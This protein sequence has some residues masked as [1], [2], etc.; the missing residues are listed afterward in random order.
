MPFL[1][2]N[3][4]ITQS[5]QQL[6]VR[7]DRKL[8]GELPLSIEYP[9]FVICL[10]TSK[11]QNAL[12]GQFSNQIISKVVLVIRMLP[13]SFKNSLPQAFCGLHFIVNI[14][15]FSQLTSFLKKGTQIL[16][17]DAWQKIV[18]FQYF[19]NLSSFMAVNVSLYTCVFAMVASL[20]VKCK[21]IFK[22]VKGKI[23]VQQK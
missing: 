14:F 21:N 7:N 20:R 11:I 1:T 12:L 2:T 6:F 18:I 9:P 16:E 5:C 4:S 22:L 3:H 8:S 13:T 15:I 19:C 23:V 10:T 17:L